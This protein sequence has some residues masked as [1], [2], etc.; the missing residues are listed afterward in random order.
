MTDAPL[1]YYHGTTTKNTQPILKEG[2]RDSTGSY[3]L[4]DC[5]LTGV[6]LSDIPLDE[7]PSSEV[8]LRVSFTS[9]PPNFDDFELMEDGKP[10]REWCVPAK[11]INGVARIEIF[12]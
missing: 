1:I 3:M 12:G 10:Y 2:F 7:G 4:Q 9:I 6:F 5:T 8:A 11:L